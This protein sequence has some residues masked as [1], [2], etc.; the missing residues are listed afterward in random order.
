MIVAEGPAAPNAAIAGYVRL[1]RRRSA[2]NADFVVSL[3]H[4]GRAK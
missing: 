4:V 2:S 3:T 1:R